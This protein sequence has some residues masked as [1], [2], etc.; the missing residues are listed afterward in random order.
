MVSKH[1][2]MVGLTLEGRG[3]STLD[4]QEEEEDSTDATASSFSSLSP[5]T[6]MY[7]PT[8]GIPPTTI[9][10]TT[11]LHSRI[12]SP[13]H[14]FEFLNGR[15]NRES[16]HNFRPQYHSTRLLQLLSKVLLMNN[17]SIHE[18]STWMGFW[19]LLFVT[20]ANYVL[21][22]MRDAVALAVGVSNLPKLT[23]ASTLLAVLSSVPIGWLFEAP[24]PKRRKLW[25]RMG[26]TRGDTQGTSLALFYRT[27]MVCIL[28]YAFGFFVYRQKGGEQNIGFQATEAN[29]VGGLWAILQQLGQLMYIAFFLVVHLMK[30]HSLS[31]IWGVTTEAME[32]EDAARKRHNIPSSKTRLGIVHGTC[33]EA[34]GIVGCRSSLVGIECRVGH[35]VGTYHAATLGRTAACIQTKLRRSGFVGS[36][37]EAIFI[38]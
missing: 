9:P 17:Y 6:Q 38:S 19:A 20:C 12:Q 32:Y 33:I 29:S 35:R 13:L 14:G 15:H 7:H 8:Q 11:E 16:H 23:L 10:D 18:N 34:I 24:D 27:F 22:P 37:H 26:L 30:L 21:S 28:S 36:K 4:E 1:S 3:I 2:V 25:K 31:L 5:D